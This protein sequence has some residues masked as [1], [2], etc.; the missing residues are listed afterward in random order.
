MGPEGHKSIPFC[1]EE[2]S[3]IS[4][5]DPPEPLN[6]CPDGLLEIFLAWVILGEP[7]PMSQDPAGPQQPDAVLNITS[8][9]CI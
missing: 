2:L 3:V 5:G 7:W 9:S 1:L 6:S 8:A 4:A